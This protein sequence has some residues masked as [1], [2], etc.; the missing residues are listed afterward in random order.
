MKRPVI[1]L[2]GGAGKRLGIDLPKCL[3]PIGGV[4]ILKRTIEY[5]NKAGF[6]ELYISTQKKFAGSIKKE[7]ADSG[8]IIINKAHRE[9]IIC[10]LVNLP[11]LISI[12]APF[13]IVLSDIYYSSNPF[14]NIAFNKKKGELLIGAEINQAQ[15]NKI[16]GVLKID[17]KKLVTDA[18][19]NPVIIKNKGYLAWT[20][21][22]YCQEEFWDD[23]LN[24]TPQKNNLNDSSLEDFIKYRIGIGR[25]F[26]SLETSH[27]IN[28]NNAFDFLSANLYE[29]QKKRKV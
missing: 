8:K 7:I 14:I 11:N 17:E 25:I 15:K 26:F 10:A 22:N 13:L 3:L 18:I 28:V 9:S 12:D 27:F 23:L 2:A 4:S 21:I 6:K 29:F 20:G 24:F 16:G 19:K 1:I 5:L